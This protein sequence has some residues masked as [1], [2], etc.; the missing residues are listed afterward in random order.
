MPRRSTRRGGAGVGTE[1]G[2]VGAS[3][4]PP[5][6]HTR[7]A[8]QVDGVKARLAQLCAGDDELTAVGESHR[9]ADGSD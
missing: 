7:E 6:G 3:F 2:A 8:E 9:R 1:D 5:F 4:Q